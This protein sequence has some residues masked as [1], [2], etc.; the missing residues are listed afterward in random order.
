MRPELTLS[1]LTG[2]RGKPFVTVPN[3]YVCVYVVLCHDYTLQQTKNRKHIIVLT[4]NDT[5][6]DR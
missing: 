6:Y 3:M 1:T 5:Q 2:N 4:Y